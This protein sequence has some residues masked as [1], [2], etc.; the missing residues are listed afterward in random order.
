MRWELGGR[1]ALVTGA[2]SGIGRALAQAL[3][4]QGVELAISARRKLELEGLADQIERSGKPRPVVLPAD[5]S[6]R[7]QAEQLARQALESLG[8]IDLL[9]NNAGVG[10]GGAQCVVGDADPARE[11]FETNYWSA[12]ALMKALVPAMRERGQGALVNVA[13]LA[14]ITPFPMTGHYA[15]SKAALA[16]ATETLRME[17]AG[18]GVRIL[19]VLPGPVETAMLAEAQAVRGLAHTI[20]RTPRG[21]PEVLASR[22]VRALRRGRKTLV[23]PASLGIARVLPTLALSAMRRMGRHIDVADPRMVRGGSGGDPVARDAR[24]EFRS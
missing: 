20:R 10:L 19:L 12:L 8:S 15:S 3:A 5:L 16:L 18:T 4:A 9:I 2:S 23:Y 11:L 13:S 24:A 1:R 22:I 6:Q 21:N 7:G 17:L 14:S